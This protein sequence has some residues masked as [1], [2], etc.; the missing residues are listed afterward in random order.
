VIWKKEFLKKE[1]VL[2][3]I[4]PALIVGGSWIIFGRVNHASTGET[5]LLAESLSRLVQGEVHPDAVY[6][7]L[8]FTAYLVIKTRVY[9]ILVPVTIGLGFLAV[10]FNSQVRKDKLSLTFLIAGMLSGAGVMFMYYLTSYDKSIDLLSWLGTGYDRMLFA[11]LVL[12]A[13]GSAL[14]IWK[15]WFK[16]ADD[17]AK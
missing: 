14:I 12:L 13:T 9:G 7:I 1:T 8:R 4:I 10:T 16:K 2:R 11:P 6:K 3:V 17:E 5:A 15:A